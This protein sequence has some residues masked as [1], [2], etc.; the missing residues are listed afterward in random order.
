MPRRQGRRGRR[1]GRSALTRGAGRPR[2][3]RPARQAL[4][5]RGG[6]RA[7][8]CR[9]GARACP[10]ASAATGTRRPRRPCRRSRSVP[11]SR[12]RRSRSRGSEPRR[13]RRRRPPRP[14]PGPAPRA[15][16]GAST[17]AP[18]AA[19]RSRTSRGP[20]GRQH[21]G[22]GHRAELDRGGADAAVRAGD[23]EHVPEAKVSQREDRV[24]RRDEDLGNRGCPCV[25]EVRRHRHD[26]TLVHDHP[27]RQASAADDPEDPVAELETSCRRAAPDHDAARLDAGDV[28]RGARRRRIPPGPLGQIGAVQGGVAHFEQ[29]VVRRSARGSGRSSNATTSFP[30]APVKTTACTASSV[31]VR[32]R[33]S[34]A[35]A[36]KSRRATA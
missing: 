8:S 15:R 1:A 4:S 20:H 5:P 13:A 27:A 12:V 25:V 6:G 18:S 36:G 19:T 22:A 7:A 26:V 34:A 2:G 14:A 24:V 10:S 11:S 28:R 33:E 30:P 16:S 17:S 29:D 3:R 31:V 9:S 21:A 32:P 35:S 23:A